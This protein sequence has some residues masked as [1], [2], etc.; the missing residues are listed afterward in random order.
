MN[1]LEIVGLVMSIAFIVLGIG[2]VGSWIEDREQEALKRGSG[3][4]LDH[5]DP[6]EDLGI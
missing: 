5:F 4:P 6:D 3:E 1:W 2:M